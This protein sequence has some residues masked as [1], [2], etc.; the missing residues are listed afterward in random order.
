[1]SNFTI[2][3][4]KV[5]HL[6]LRAKLYLDKENASKIEINAL[7][8]MIRNIY[9]ECYSLGELFKCEGLLLEKQSN[10]NDALKAY[11]IALKFQPNNYKLITRIADIYEYIFDSHRKAE[12]LYLMAYKLNME[13]LQTLIGLAR[14]KYF[15]GDIQL[16]KEYI[17]RIPDSEHKNPKIVYIKALI[18]IKENDCSLATQL[19]NLIKDLNVEEIYLSQVSMLISS[20]KNKT[21][22][23]GYKRTFITCDE[24][25]TQDI[26]IE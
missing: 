7:E 11:E 1:M 6:I 19:L 17:N 5:N 4:A 13:Y 9:D 25:P 15:I 18:A 21:L 10:N 3:T 20:K 12:T 16:S 26:E 14:V 22:E 23:S 8:K 24:R 2:N